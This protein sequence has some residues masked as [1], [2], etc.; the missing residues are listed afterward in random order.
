MSDLQEKIIELGFQLF[1][2]KLYWVAASAWWFYEYF[3]TFDDEVNYAWK[4]RKTPV[5]WLFILNRYLAPCYIVITLFAYFSPQWTLGVCSRYGFME[6]F[7][8]VTLTTTAQLFIALRV[9]AITA[10]H[11]LFPAFTILV[12]LAQWGIAIYAMSQ[13]SLGTD[14]VALLLPVR[15]DIDSSV[16]ATIPALPVLPTIDPYHICI[17][18]STLTVT[19]Y[20]KAFLGLA[21]AYD[22]IAFLVIFGVTLRR[23]RSYKLLPIIQVIQRDGIMY[24]LILFSSNLLWVLLIQYAPPA[25]KFLHNQ[26]AMLVSSVMITRITLNLKK[27]SQS[28]TVISWGVHTFEATPWQALGSNAT[29]L[30][31]FRAARKRSNNEG[32]ETMY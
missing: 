4:G 22:T 1:S 17:F 25:L 27:A 13:S 12:L 32:S 21:L 18:I 14:Q 5:F 9:Y 11:K 31:T 29:E 26:P 28:Q 19:P 30:S 23:Q 24:F 10:K 6:T 2:I 15:R 20:V 7:E 8:T 3:L 16:A